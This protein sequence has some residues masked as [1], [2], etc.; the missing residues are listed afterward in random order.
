[1]FS[2]FVV[3]NYLFMLTCLRT[4]SLTGS[5]KLSVVLMMVMLSVS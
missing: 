5:G 3:S 2:V 4:C 1:M